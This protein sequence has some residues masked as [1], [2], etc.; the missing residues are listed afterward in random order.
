MIWFVAFAITHLA[1]LV[2]GF[3][4]GYS[5]CKWVQ[6]RKRRREGTET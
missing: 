2:C 5:V 4:L 1:F 3:G 6:W